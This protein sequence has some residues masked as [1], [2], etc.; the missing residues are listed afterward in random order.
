MKERYFLYLLIFLG[1]IKLYQYWWGLFDY[2][3]Q[4]IN[5]AYALADTVGR[6]DY[7]YLT[8]DRK[9]IEP[10]ELAEG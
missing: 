4:Q 10:D 6:H 2:I 9:V 8:A 5:R 1:S 3:S 7:R